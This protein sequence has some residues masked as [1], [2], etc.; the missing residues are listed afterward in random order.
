[1]GPTE[2]EAALRD[3]GY[4]QQAI[5]KMSGEQRA[6][7]LKTCYQNKADS[8]EAALANERH[9]REVRDA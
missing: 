9:K 7:T 6:L 2:A 1:M 3:F 8:T 4:T 5:D